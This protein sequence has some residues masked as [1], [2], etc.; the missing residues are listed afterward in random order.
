MN[1]IAH[2]HPLPGELCRSRV[3]YDDGARERCIRLRGHTGR[4]EFVQVMPPRPV[5]EG[6]A[7]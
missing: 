6:G 5:Q 7:P 1:A 4:C 2:P 3:D